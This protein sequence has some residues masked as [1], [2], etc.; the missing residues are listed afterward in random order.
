[1]SFYINLNILIPLG[2][3]ALCRSNFVQHSAFW[4]RQTRCT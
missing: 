1:V 3:I 4:P 2:A